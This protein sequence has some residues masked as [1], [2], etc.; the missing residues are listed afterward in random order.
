[1]VL[2]DCCD[3]DCDCGRDWRSMMIATTLYR[4]AQCY[5]KT[6]TTRKATAIWRWVC[7]GRKGDAHWKALGRPLLNV[8]A[9]KIP[10]ELSSSNRH[11]SSRGIEG[12]SAPT[13]SSSSCWRHVELLQSIGWYA[14]LGLDLGA[15]TVDQSVVE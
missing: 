13:T 5:G 8:E 7:A 9:S 1:V 2:V 12:T 11:C 15:A 6:A 3:C 10:V 4:D 14:S